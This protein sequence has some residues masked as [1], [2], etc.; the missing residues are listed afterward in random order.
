MTQPV[1]HGY[2]D[3]GRYVS[4][5][6]KLLLSTG[7]VASD[8]PV[9][10]DLSFVGDV[11]A[12]GIFLNATTQGQTFQFKWNEQPGGV[13][14]FTS[15]QFEL[16]AGVTADR[17][18]PVLGPY[19]TVRVT[20][21]AAGGSHSLS[22]WTGPRGAIAMDAL[23]S[24]NV[25]INATAVNVLAAGVDTRNASRVWPGEAFWTVSSLAATWR[26]VLNMRTAAGAVTTIDSMQGTAAGTLSHQVF[27]PL[28]AMQVVYTNTSAGAANYDTYLVGR[29]I[30]SGA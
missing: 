14:Q 12:I 6:D 21:A 3:W 20:P 18:I 30:E 15:T 24:R 26:A 28:R 4:R 22:A 7:T 19:C 25:L 29:S 8:V 5:A 23:A 1:G 16:V 9:D 17:F 10:Y 13:G 27:L 11:E 2:P